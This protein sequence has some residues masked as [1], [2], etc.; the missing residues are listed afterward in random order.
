MTRKIFHEPTLPLKSEPQSPEHS[1]TGNSIEG[2]DTMSTRSIDSAYD[3]RSSS[4]TAQQFSDL[5]GPYSAQPRISYQAQPSYPASREH[6]SLPPLRDLDRVT[7][8]ESPY[9]PTSTTYPSPYTTSTGP[10]P[11]QDA[12]SYGSDRTPYYDPSTRYGQAYPP[13]AR[14]TPQMDFARYAP[15][16]YDYRA[17]IPYGPS[18]GSSDY[19]PSPTGYHQPTSPPVAMDANGSNRRRRGNLP[20]HITDILRAWFHDHLEHPYPTEDEKQVLVAR[21]NLSMN[22]ISNWFIN[23]RRRQLPAL[24]HAREREQNAAA[25]AYEQ[26]QLRRQHQSDSTT[27]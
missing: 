4:W 21:T 14:Q 24:R 16:P 13:V 6:S 3:R 5:T 20:R 22:Q 27:R 23:A 15:S 17:S 1:Q 18:Y 12:Y 19:A 7:N 9:S 25:A 2:Y 11:G 10:H 26:D 8:F